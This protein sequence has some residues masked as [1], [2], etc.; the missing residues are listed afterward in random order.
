MECPETVVITLEDGLNE[1]GANYTKCDSHI[2]YAKCSFYS[3]IIL[4]NDN[5]QK[6]YSL[7]P[8]SLRFNYWLEE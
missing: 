3:S 2:K 6:D 8:L 7:N 5:P 1:M 4:R